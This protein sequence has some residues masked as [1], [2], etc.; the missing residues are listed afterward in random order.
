MP[1]ARHNVI[2]QVYRCLVCGAEV[3]VIKG[4]DGDLA[5]HCCNQPM[6]LLPRRHCAYFCPVCGAEVMTVR[7]GPGDLTP[8]CC[9]QPMRLRRPAA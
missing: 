4:A 1:E 9:N 5:P 3:S 6:V 8:H 2:G 7:I